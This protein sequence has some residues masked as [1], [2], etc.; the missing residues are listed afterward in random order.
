MRILWG[1][2]QVA[3][4]GIACDMHRLCAW[5]S[6]GNMSNSMMRDSPFFLGMFFTARN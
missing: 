5:E 4:I 1:C 3:H 2:A 6:H